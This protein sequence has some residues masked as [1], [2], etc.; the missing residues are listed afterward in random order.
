MS[1]QKVFRTIRPYLYVIPAFFFVSIFV[2]F[3]MFRALYLSLFRWN[4]AVPQRVFIGFSNYVQAWNTPLFWQVIRNNII[5][6]LLTVPMSIALG[7]LFAVLVNKKI[8]GKGFYRVALF[9]PHIIPFVAIAMLWLWILSPDYGI[10][11]YYLGKIGFPSIRW[12]T[13]RRY[14]LLAIVFVSVW[15]VFGYNTIILLAGLQSIPDEFYE[16]AEIDGATGWRKFINI[17]FPLLAPTTFFVF[18]MAIIGSFQSIDAVY[19]MTAGGP[20]NATNLFVY[21]IYQHSFL[22][23]NTGYAATLTSILLLGLLISIVLIF[24]IIGKRIHYG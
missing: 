13:D 12:L 5:Y 10:I 17:T 2:Y 21:Y 15:R 22:F 6:M 19:V 18:I 23:W 20:A 14:A 24:R 11:N 8:R 16:A 4:L 1:I 3:P 9:Y 7:L